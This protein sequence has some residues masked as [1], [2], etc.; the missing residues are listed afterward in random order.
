MA[1]PSPRDYRQPPDH[2]SLPVDP[3]VSQ[4]SLHIMGQP[5][6]LSSLTKLLF[7]SHSSDKLRLYKLI[8]QV[9]S[10]VHTPWADFLL[11]TASL[12]PS[13]WTWDG[14]YIFHVAANVFLVLVWGIG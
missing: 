5:S 13:H 4:G 8:G 7:P 6:R 12:L 10:C 14:F 9:P 1:L 2:C 3:A 11:C